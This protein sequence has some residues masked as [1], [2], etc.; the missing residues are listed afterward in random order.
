MYIQIELR[1]KLVNNYRLQYFDKILQGIFMFALDCLHLCYILDKDE[2][3]FKKNNGNMFWRKK[4]TVGLGSFLTPCLG[5]I[6][7]REPFKMGTVVNVIE[8]PIKGLL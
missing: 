7:P 8:T 6:T 1:E 2:F 5:G 3:L 4:T